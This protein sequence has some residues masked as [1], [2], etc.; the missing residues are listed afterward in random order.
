MSQDDH[1]TASNTTLEEI[2]NTVKPPRK[3][4]TGAHV[5]GIAEH[6]AW[7]L[8]MQGPEATDLM[9]LVLEFVETLYDEA[10]DGPPAEAKKS[11]TDW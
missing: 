1:R 11:L 8:I 2:L 5:V 7:M 6:D 10:E 3:D 4:T 9:R